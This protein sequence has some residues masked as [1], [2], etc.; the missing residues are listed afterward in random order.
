MDKLEKRKIISRIE[1]FF[2][3]NYFVKQ[4]TDNKVI[5]ELLGKD[6]CSGYDLIIECM[7]DCLSVSINHAKMHE[8]KYININIDASEEHINTLEEL[9]IS[10]ED[11]LTLYDNYICKLS[12]IIKENHLLDNSNLYIRNVLDNTIILLTPNLTLEIGGGCCDIYVT[13]LPHNTIIPLIGINTESA[14]IETLY[15]ILSFFLG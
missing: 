7:D 10:L 2:E 8:Q 11:Q 1:E 12:E 15:D 5:I 3:Q 9:L 13:I 14:D 6:H 4:T